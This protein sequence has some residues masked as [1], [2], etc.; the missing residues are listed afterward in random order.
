M[1]IIRPKIQILDKEH[2]KLIL[3]EAKTI[4]ETQGVFIENQ[5][6]ITLFEEKGINRDGSRFFIPSDLIDKCLQ[7]TPSEIK[8]FDR[9]GIEQISL[10]GDEIHFDPGS[11]AIFILDETSG[12]IREAKQKD[13]IRFSKIVEQLKY[14]DAQSTA[15]VYQDVPKEA[16]DWHRLYTA[17]SN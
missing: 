7:T 3:D 4:L 11:A 1:A 17:L 5:D 13:F 9:E 16:Q 6:A 8:L 14:I 12:E 2:K 15:L 10:K